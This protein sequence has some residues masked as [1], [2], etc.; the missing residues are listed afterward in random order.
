MDVSGCNIPGGRRTGTIFQS[1]PRAA[2]ANTSA[3]LVLR[4]THSPR[5]KEAY[6]E[7]TPCSQEHYH[8]LNIE[9]WG[10]HGDSHLH[11]EGKLVVAEIRF[12]QLLVS[13]KS[14]PNTRRRYVSTTRCCS[15]NLSGSGSA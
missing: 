12:S 10:M 14:F 11:T 1:D 6:I 5:H 8:C 7:H 15:A 3:Q 13:H 2:S 4:M 9:V